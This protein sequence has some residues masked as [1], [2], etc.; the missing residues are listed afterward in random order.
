MTIQQFILK[1]S[2]HRILKAEKIRNKG[3]V[4]SSRGLSNH[5]ALRILYKQYRMMFWMRTKN[6]IVSGITKNQTICTKND[7]DEVQIVAQKM[8]FFLPPEQKH[9]K[10]NE[11]FD[12]QFIILV[13]KNTDQLQ[14]YQ[15]NNL[16]IFYLNNQDLRIIFIIATAFLSKNIDRYVIGKIITY[17]I[18]GFRGNGKAPG[19]TL[20][21][22]I[23]IIPFAIVISWAILQF[24]QNK[25]LKYLLE[26]C[27]SRN[28]YFHD[29]IILK[30]ILR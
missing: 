17:F 19:T 6:I 11:M 30:A 9:P 23:V 12:E 10:P 15:E 8:P 13:S 4:S 16:N 22:S 1:G 24:L 14:S 20:S 26:F 29:W 3:I 7:L 2:I 21:V 27:R 28:D 5:D 25:C 18:S